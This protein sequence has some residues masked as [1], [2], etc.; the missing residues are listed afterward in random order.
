MQNRASVCATVSAMKQLANC[1]DIVGNRVVVAC[2][3]IPV[4]AGAGQAHPHPRRH[5]ADEAHQRAQVSPDGR[6]IVATVV[7]PAYDEDAQFSDL[8]LIDT[9]AHTRADG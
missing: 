2:L 1:G 7:E 9:A 3:A 5:L 4:G 6:W 8:W